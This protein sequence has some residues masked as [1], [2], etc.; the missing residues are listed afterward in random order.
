[1]LVAD[2][3]IGIAPENLPQVFE[4]FFQAEHGLDRSSGGLGIGLTMARSMLELH[5]GRIEARSAGLGRG[6]EMIVRL[7]ISEG[8]P[9]ESQQPS[10][11]TASLD[12]VKLESRRMMIV[13]DNVDA[14]D[15]MAMLLRLAGHEVEAA[16]DGPAALIA[17]DTFK[18]E[19]LLV[20]IGLPGMDGYELA[21]Q[22]RLRPALTA[23]LLVAMTGYGRPQ[24]RREAAVAGFDH[25]LTKPVSLEAL[26]AVLAGS[27]RRASGRASG[28]SN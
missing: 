7:P 17:A 6:T 9:G 8:Q 20:D 13:D 11:P 3:G 26:L 21:R 12:S 27:P 2:D 10:A 5:Q 4:L 28:Q 15:S 18:P 22:M 19:V 1:V 14:A 23:A 25:H 16:Y 24:D